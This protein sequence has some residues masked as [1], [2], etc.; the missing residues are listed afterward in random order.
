MALHLSGHLHEAAHAYREALREAPDD[1]PVLSNYGGLLCSLGKFE[2]ARAPLQR[3][4]TIDPSFADGWCNL[5]NCFLKLQRYNDAIAAYRNCLRISPTDARALSNLGLALDYCGE[6][7]LA[8]KFHQ[9]AVRLD[10]DNVQTR[11]NNAVSLLSGGDYLNGFREYEWRWVP[12]ESR[13]ALMAQPQWT[14]KAVPGRTVLIHGDGGF[15]DMLQF[16][17]FV[18]EVQRRC[19]RTIVRVKRDL[20]ALLRRSFPDTLFVSEDEPVPAHDLQCPAMSLAYAVGATLETLP[21]AAGY[22]RADAGKVATWRER[23]ALDAPPVAGQ[24]RTPL[25]IGLVW[26]GAPHRDVPGVALADQRRSTDLASFAPLAEAVP[27]ALVYSLQIGERAEQART[28]PGGMRV[29]DHTALLRDFDDTAALVSA[30]DV[31]VAVDTSTAHLAAGLGKPTLML[32][33]FDQCW[34][35]LSRRADSPWYDT[36]RIYRQATPFDWSDPIRR[37]CADLQKL[38]AH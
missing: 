22:L 37:V 28:P 1:A 2:E 9:A 18:P 7:A 27:D 20:L 3:A 26:A 16:V 13:N 15:G 12:P 35:W 24:G 30:L 11:M 10:P 34:R 6:N 29:I 25:R 8:Q 31:I 4:V 14:G 5:G 19:G 33:R 36:L 17:R 23:I 21:H 32:S 38:A